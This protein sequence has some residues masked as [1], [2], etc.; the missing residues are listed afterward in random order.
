M[1][2][3]SKVVLS[4]SLIVLLLVKTCTNLANTAI[5]APMPIAFKAS[6]IALTPILASLDD[7]SVLFAALS[8][9][10]IPF[11]PFSPLSSAV[12]PT[13]SIDLSKDFTSFSASPV[14]TFISISLVIIL[15]WFS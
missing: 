10:S 4:A 5:T 3:V 8:T 15:N 14:F 13:P 6:P 12:L 9:F 1:L 2:I 7:F 11:A